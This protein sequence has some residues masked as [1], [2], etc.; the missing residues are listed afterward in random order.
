MNCRYCN[1]EMII[2]DVDKQFKGCKDVY[3]I[4]TKCT[5]F[6]IAQIRFSQLF[7]ELW[8]NENDGVVDETIKHKIDFK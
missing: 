7:R 1:T 4:C 5:G 3:Y 2:D 6:C 8:H